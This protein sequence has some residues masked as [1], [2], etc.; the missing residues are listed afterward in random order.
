MNKLIISNSVSFDNKDIRQTI[1]EGK[2]YYSVIDVIISLEYTKYYSQ[3]WNQLKDRHLNQSQPIWL[4]LKMQASD[5][6][7]YYTD[8]S[9]REQMFEIITYIPSPKVS[10]FRKWLASLAEAEF[11]K[12]E[13][14]NKTPQQKWVETR[15][16]GKVVRK[17][18]T[19]SLVQ[20]GL[21]PDEIPLTTNTLYRYGLEHTAASL[22]KHKGLKDG[23][24]V[25]NHMNR[26]ELLVTKNMEAVLDELMDINNSQGFREVSQDAVEA[27]EFGSRMRRDIE[28]MTGRP[29]VSKENNLSPKKKLDTKKDKQLVI[30]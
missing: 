14:E 15:E 8:A 7:S 23:T 27:G 16:E 26:L 21:K 20:H 9:T 18:L 6:K 12:M 22:R 30:E 24:N 17:Q 1:H 11:Q 25:R 3:A 19:S 4:Q 29:V 28:R 2:V 13:S 5:G 10:S